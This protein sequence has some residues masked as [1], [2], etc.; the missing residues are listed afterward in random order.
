MTIGVEWWMGACLS[1]ACRP[2]RPATLAERDVSLRRVAASASAEANFKDHNASLWPCLQ[3]CCLVRGGR[4]P[5]PPMTL[6]IK[7]V[8][9]PIPRIRKTAT[10][11]SFTVRS[12]MPS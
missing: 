6:P 7:A 3:A 5:K 8:R 4:S 2:W 10:R 11:W 1:I 9:L 12:L